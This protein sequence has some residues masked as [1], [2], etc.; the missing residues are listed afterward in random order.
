MD[1][2]A[3]AL[4]TSAG[5]DD[6]EYVVTRLSQFLNPI[7]IITL[8]GQQESRSSNEDIERRWNALMGE[9]KKIEERSEELAIV[10]DV[11]SHLGDIVENNHPKVSY[12]GQL[13]R[14]FVIPGNYILVN[15]SP[16]AKGGP[17]TRYDPSDA[18]S[19]DKKSL[20]DLVIISK[21][22]ERYLEEMVIDKDLLWTPFSCN[23]SAKTKYS[24]HYSILT[25]FKNIPIKEEK[26]KNGARE[27]FWNTNKKGGWEKYF[28]YTDRN[29]ILDSIEEE[30]AMNVNPNKM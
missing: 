24:D 21:G 12:G 18:K 17:F 28:K 8:Y 4:K 26:I 15:S 1:E 14:D 9:V 30:A 25:V 16:K 3:A 20:L 7:N 13:V 29:D 5:K 23:A 10:S 22:L 6:N 11:N 2:A 27:T 19:E